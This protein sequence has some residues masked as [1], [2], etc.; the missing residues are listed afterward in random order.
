M[1]QGFSIPHQQ[2]VPVPL[3]QQVQVTEHRIPMT[4]GSQCAEDQRCE[5]PNIHQ[6]SL[7]YISQSVP[8]A[9][10]PGLPVIYQKETSVAPVATTERKYQSINR[11]PRST[12]K[13]YYNIH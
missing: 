12:I 5:T 10:L 6:N 9:Y 2:P 7:R 11:R 4:F 1:L 8:L 3:S 13:Y